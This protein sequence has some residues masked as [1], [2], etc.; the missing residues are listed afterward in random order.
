[1]VMAATIDAAAAA[2]QVK[3]KTEWT[4]VYIDATT[5]D[6]ADDERGTEVGH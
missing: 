5:D 4:Q 6:D 3:H 1:M 2:G